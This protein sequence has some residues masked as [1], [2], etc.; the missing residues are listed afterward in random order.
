M[1]TTRLLLYVHMRVS[2]QII[3]E[4]QRVSS[5]C[6][7]VM[8]S[9]E[10]IN[11]F[12]Q[13]FSF[14]AVRDGWKPASFHCHISRAVSSLPTSWTLW[15][16]LYTS[17]HIYEYSWCMFGAPKL[18]GSMCVFVWVMNGAFCSRNDRDVCGKVSGKLSI[19]HIWWNSGQAQY[20]LGASD[21]ISRAFRRN[22]FSQLK[23]KHGYYC[24]LQRSACNPK[25]SNLGIGNA[26]MYSTEAIWFYCS[27]SS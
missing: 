9:G 15:T 21:N 7:C 5:A 27:I 4:Y 18:I 22:C 19:N 11:W 16:P 12:F 13:Q 20:I 24:Q 8:T 25:Q 10:F 14:W 6:A 1:R 26:R 23:A 17:I 3:S 2:F